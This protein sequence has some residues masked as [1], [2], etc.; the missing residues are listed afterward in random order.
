[1]TVRFD[2]GEGFESQVP[3]AVERSGPAGSAAARPLTSSPARRPR[4]TCARRIEPA[5]E[6]ASSKLESGAAPVD[7]ARV[8]IE[9]DEH[10]VARRILEVLDH[11]LTALRGRRPVDAPQ[12]LALLVLAHAVQV[13]ALGRRSSRRRPSCRREP[14]SENSRS[15]STSRG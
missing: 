2:G 3:V 1:M 12:R 4:P 5:A 7:E 15:S 8:G 14:V 13:E 6:T 11:Q 9:Q 10:L